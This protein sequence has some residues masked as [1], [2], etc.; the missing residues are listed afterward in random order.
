[1]P[2][3]DREKLERMYMAFRRNKGLAWFG[4]LWLGAECVLR[5]PFFKKMAVGWRVLSL[6]GTAFA[7]KCFFQF[8][9][10]QTYG[11]ILSAFFRKY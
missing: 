5:I 8:Q 3:E 4:G 7:F 11:P 2:L 9:N 6:F 10:G 1:V